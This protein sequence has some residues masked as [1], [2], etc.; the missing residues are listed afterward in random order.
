MNPVL[1]SAVEPAVIDHRGHRRALDQRVRR[2]MSGRFEGQRDAVAEGGVDQ[3][4]AERGGQ[5]DAAPVAADP[6]LE[7]VGELVKPR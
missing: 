1:I 3:D 6:G 4:R 5:R 2:D 7:P